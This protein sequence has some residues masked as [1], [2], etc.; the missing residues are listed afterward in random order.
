MSLLHRAIAPGV[1]L[2]RAGVWRTL[3]L[4]VRH[5]TH[6]DLADELAVPSLSTIGKAWS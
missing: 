2:D 4:L 3:V 5:L 1:G 6:L